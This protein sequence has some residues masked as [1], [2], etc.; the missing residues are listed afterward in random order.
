MAEMTALSVIFI[1][2][3]ADV[4]TY[5][6]KASVGYRDPDSKLQDQQTRTSKSKAQQAC[7]PAW[8][9]YRGTEKCQE[10]VAEI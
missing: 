9:K 2:W 4:R 6:L 3:G 8:V 7:L 5:E 10:E 1:I